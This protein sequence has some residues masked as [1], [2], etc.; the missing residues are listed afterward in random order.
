MK[1][2]LTSQ[3]QKAQ[4]DD[5]DFEW[6][7]HFKWTAS[8]QGFVKKF[9]A[10]RFEQIPGTRVRYKRKRKGITKYAY[11]CK[12]RKVWMH[13]E[14]MKCPADKVIDHIDGNGLN[15]CKQNLRIVTYTE[16]AQ[17]AMAKTRAKT[18]PSL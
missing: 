10:I 7:Q 12:R 6:L 14:I 18:E 11:R 3:G 5:D 8:R 15:N 2:I 4:V 17:Y 16:N 13:R 9:Y 1:E